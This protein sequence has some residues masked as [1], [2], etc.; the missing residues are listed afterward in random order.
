MNPK[1]NEEPRLT[2][3]VTGFFRRLKLF[4]DFVDPAVLLD[5][6]DAL[7][8]PELHELSELLE[9]DAISTSGGHL[10]DVED[11]KRSTKKTWVLADATTAA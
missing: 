10:V 4:G 3:I 9:A 6:L 8:T 11:G 5:L 1:E 2:K 7:A